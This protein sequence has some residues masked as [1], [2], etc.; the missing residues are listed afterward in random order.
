M[1]A[2]R[3]SIIV[4]TFNSALTIEHALQSVFSQSQNAC[5]V[6]VIDGGST[7]ATLSIIQQHHTRIAHVVSEK[8]NGI[9]D[10]INKGLNLASGEWIFIL[11]SDDT[12]D[13][14]DVF[15]EMLAAATPTTQL[16]FGNVKY[17][18]I[19]QTLVPLQHVSSFSKKLYWKNTLHQQ[20]VLY[21]R[22]LFAHF[23]FNTNYKVL[24]DYDLH[25]H[26]FNEKAAS[27]SV[28]ITVARCAAQGLSKRFKWNLYREELTIKRK[29]LSLALWLMNIPWVMSKFLLK[30]LP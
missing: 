3:I 16:I 22:D 30:Q 7:D 28:P 26:L 13:H 15:T 21:R 6:I 2:L 17:I 1:N 25:L 8:D 11:G 27:T 10:A 19:K 29:R 14:V 4:P 5:E 23:R 9:Y 24:A 20:G 12:L 18:G